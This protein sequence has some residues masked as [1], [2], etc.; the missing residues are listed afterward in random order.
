MLAWI[1]HLTRWCL[2][3]TLETA[4]D[5]EINEFRTK[6]RHWIS[7]SFS[8]VFLL[9][10]SY[11]SDPSLANCIY[12]HGIHRGSQRGSFRCLSS[13]E[14]YPEYHEKQLPGTDVPDS[15][16]QRSFGL[17][18]SPARAKDE[19]FDHPMDAEGDDAVF[20]QYRQNTGWQDLG[21]LAS[22]PSLEK[23]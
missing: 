22:C 2:F 17:H 19:T 9:N 20:E 1:M 13:K 3:G 11:W 5:L 15:F 8:L 16:A 7:S 23:I 21:N 10:W 18:P 12:L 6:H 14:H 4:D